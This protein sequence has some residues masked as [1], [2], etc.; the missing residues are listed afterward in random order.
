MIDSIRQKIARGDLSDAWRMMTSFHDLPVTSPF[1]PEKQ[2][3]PAARDAVLFSSSWEALDYYYRGDYSSARF[4]LERILYK[5]EDEG[6]F[7]DD[8]KFTLA[9]YF[10]TCLESNHLKGLDDKERLLQNVDPQSYYAV[11]WKLLT[12]LASENFDGATDVISK[13]RSHLASAKPGSAHALFAA[14]LV[15]T[16]M[17]DFAQMTFWS[18]A[19]FQSI[20]SERSDL[21]P[22]GLLV[23]AI[24]FFIAG[25]PANAV[26]TVLAA[27]KS[28]YAGQPNADEITTQVAGSLLRI[29]QNTFGKQED[30]FN[31]EP[32]MF[33]QTSSIGKTEWRGLMASVT[34][35]SEL[36]QL[37][38]PTKNDLL[39]LGL[40]K[41]RLLVHIQEYTQTGRIPQ[42]E[43][44]YRNFIFLLDGIIHQYRQK[45]RALL[46]LK[47]INETN[48]ALHKAAAKLIDSVQGKD[49]PDHELGGYQTTETEIETIEAYLDEAFNDFRVEL[50]TEPHGRVKLEQMARISASK[51]FFSRNGQLISGWPPTGSSR[52]D[53]QDW[54]K[55]HVPPQGFKAYRVLDVHVIVAGP[56]TWVF[57]AAELRKR[58]EALTAANLQ[59]S[60]YVKTHEPIN[61]GTSQLDD[62]LAE[63]GVHLIGRS[64][65]M[66]KVKSILVR[67]KQNQSESPVLITGETGTGKEIVANA[68]HLVSPRRRN[69]FTALNCGVFT[70]ELIAAELFGYVKGAYTG[71]SKD[72]PGAIRDTDKGTLF[73]D[74]IGELPRDQ[75]PALLRF[76]ENQQVRPVGGESKVYTVDVRIVAAT[77]QPADLGDESKNLRNDLIARLSVIR[78]HLPPL[79]ERKEDIE[80][81]AYHF[82]KSS[83]DYN[84]H[85]FSE[86]AV[87]YLV[88]QPW[89]GNIR[90]LRNQ[91]HGVLSILPPNRTLIQP[92]DFEA[93]QQMNVP[94]TTSPESTEN[95]P[96]YFDLSQ[97]RGG[98]LKRLEK[99]VVA[100]FLNSEYLR[101]G[102]NWSAVQK[103]Y[104]S[105]SRSTLFR[106]RKTQ[107]D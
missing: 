23:R 4:V 68:I 107:E 88:G 70:R 20:I 2:A 5:Y 48:P 45:Q 15:A 61:D 87:T 81:L 10:R 77:N 93:L 52:R 49:R 103:A 58:I 92:Q 19:Y 79:R 101:L 43:N 95:T 42:I 32:D 57:E 30:G 102:Q 18:D 55:S 86:A 71:A 33:L 27:Y 13:V 34:N 12:A 98:N 29:I 67:L 35:I 31:Y 99:D 89:P 28:V 78:L 105:I 38:T 65:A 40:I 16:V 59:L 72:S 44:D 84:E 90:Q 97:Y 96:L 69:K 1:P 83:P 54:T 56:M 80:P 53:I 41:P 63:V 14:W 6:V 37:H 9:A 85:R 91:I 22:N 94:Q 106:R 7:N 8:F 74:E 82:L 62:E 17:G 3:W 75:Q 47:R 21:M 11:Y 76:L 73:L 66:T 100:F 25:D 104:P 39:Q 24:T 51:I 60:S 26:R 64:P 46:S 36:Y 50:A